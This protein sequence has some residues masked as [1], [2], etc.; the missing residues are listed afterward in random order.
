MIGFQFLVENCDKDEY[1]YPMIKIDESLKVLRDYED[2]T[3]RALDIA[4]L[5]S[6]LFRIRSV[7]LALGGN[8]AFGAYVNAKFETPFLELS[9]ISGKVYPRLLQEIMAGQLKATG[10]LDRWVLEG[11]E[12]IIQ[13]GKESPLRHLYRDFQ[14]EFGPYKLVPIEELIAERLVAGTFPIPNETAYY[15][16]FELV[17]SGMME[18]VAVDWGQLLKL[19]GQPEYRVEDELAD[20]RQRVKKELDEEGFVGESHE[21]TPDEVP[22]DS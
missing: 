7:V 3:E 18:Q 5:V 10:M 12:I 15:E 22:S 9:A 1:A 11:I 16:A 21:Q 4:G 17:K 8:L 19:C 6:T 13:P 14:T 20:I 2:L